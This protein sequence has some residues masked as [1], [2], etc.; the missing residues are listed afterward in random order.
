MTQRLPRPRTVAW[1][2]I[3]LQLQECISPYRRTLWN[4]TPGGSIS[5]IA[6]EKGPAELETHVN[7]PRMTSFIALGKKICTA[8]IVVAPL[9]GEKLIC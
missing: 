8:T 2:K 9:F 5:V 1:F 4:S 3:R 7:K 6:A